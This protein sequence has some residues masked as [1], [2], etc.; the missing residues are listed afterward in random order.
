MPEFVVVI[1]DPRVKNP[2]T[3]PVRVIGISDLEYNEKHK[4]L[5]VLPTIKAN[6]K[7]I[8]IIKPPLNIGVVRIWKNRATREK[9]NLVGRIVGDDSLDLQEVGIP[10]GFLT[11]KLGTSQAMGEILSA[12]SFQ[13]RVSDDVASKFMGLKIGDRVDGR[14]IGFPNTILEIRGG[15]DLAGFPMRLDIDGA[16]KKYV[17]LSS[18]S[19]FR[20]RERG[21]RRRKLVRGNT[22][23]PD[24]VQINTVVVVQ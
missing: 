13:I 4:E 15:S 9:V 20:P 1:S 2:R 21:E 3:I 22:I 24:I 17:L 8:E 11:E 23:S 12:P 18:G 16:V 6:S 19:G 14:V 5:R 7:L 10:Q